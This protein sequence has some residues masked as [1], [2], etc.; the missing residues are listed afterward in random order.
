MLTLPAIALRR[1]AFPLARLEILGYE[2]IV[3]LAAVGGYADRVRSIEYAA[4]AGF[5]NPKATLDPEL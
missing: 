3:S 4:M 2:H 1:E 5:F